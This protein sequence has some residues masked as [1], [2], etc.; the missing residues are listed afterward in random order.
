MTVTTHAKAFSLLVEINRANP[1]FNE[2]IEQIMDLIT[3]FSV[4]AENAVDIAESAAARL[5]RIEGK[6]VNNMAYNASIYRG[7]LDKIRLPD[8]SHGGDI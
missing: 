2:K 1:E 7:K 5:E 4:I 6:D 8:I 3:E